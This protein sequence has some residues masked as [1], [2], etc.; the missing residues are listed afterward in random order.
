MNKTPTNTHVLLNTDEYDK[1]LPEMENLVCRKN[2]NGMKPLVKQLSDLKR[3]SEGLPTHVGRAFCEHIAVFGQCAQPLSCASRHSLNDNDVP[4]GRLPRQGQVELRI[5]SV[6]SPSHFLVEVLPA[7]KKVRQQWQHDQ[8]ALKLDLAS[9]FADKA[10]RVPRRAELLPGDLC[11][12]LVGQYRRARVCSNTSP[13]KVSSF[14][15]VEV[16][17]LETGNKFRLQPGIDEILEM[18]ERFRDLLPQVIDAHLLGFIPFEEDSQWCPSSLNHLKLKLSFFKNERFVIKATVAMVLGQRLYLSS[19]KVLEHLTC[20]VP[21]LSLDIKEW[22][23]AQ[24][25]AKVNSKGLNLLRKMAEEFGEYLYL[26]GY[27]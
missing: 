12:I 13:G 19:L 4:D 1:F 17:C 21:I 25:F 14:V 16:Q 20:G 26:F 3:R 2:L 9:F 7:N 22:L 6:I 27:I 18:P 5:S 24:S 23:L 11:I 10:N 15:Y 8:L